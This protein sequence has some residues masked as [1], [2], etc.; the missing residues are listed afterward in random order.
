MDES[1]NGQ[2]GGTAPND[3]DCDDS[4]PEAY[5]GNPE[6]SPQAQER[7]MTAFKQVLTNLQAGQRPPTAQPPSRFQSSRLAFARFRV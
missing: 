7:V 1:F 2:V 6:L 5:P 4:E 3:N